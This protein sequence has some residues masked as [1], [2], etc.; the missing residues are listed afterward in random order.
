MPR[1]GDYPNAAP[2]YPNRVRTNPRGSWL[3]QL[4]VTAIGTLFLYK[5]IFTDY[6]VRRTCVMHVYTAVAAITPKC[7]VALYIGRLR[8]VLSSLPLVLGVKLDRDKIGEI[9]V[10]GFVLSYS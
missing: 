2:A 4:I 10:L 9:I 8:G 5:V 1:L 7:N 3:K 6:K